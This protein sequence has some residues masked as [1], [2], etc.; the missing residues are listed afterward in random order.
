MNGYQMG[1]ME[2]RFAELIWKHAPVASGEL[3]RLCAEAFNWKKS[4]T[5]TMLHRLCERGIFENPDGTVR[6]LLTRKEYQSLQ[7]EAFVE[8]TFS[9]S[10]PG[11][12]AAFASR[13]ALSE[14]D[15]AALEQLIDAYRKEEE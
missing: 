9:G 3:V 2:F 12:L 6:A 10:L 14:E 7:T 4:T 11:F 13:R 5:Y 1:E 15:V 8:E